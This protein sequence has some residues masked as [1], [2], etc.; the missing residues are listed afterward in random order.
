[1]KG[2]A[3]ENEALAER[4]RE[5]FKISTEKKTLKERQ[6]FGDRFTC[7]DKNKMIQMQTICNGVGWTVD[8]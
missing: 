7:D 5:T 3:T 4:M 1:M 6:H 2:E 8:A